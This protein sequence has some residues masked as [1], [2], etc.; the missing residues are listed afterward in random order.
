M[1]CV[2]ARGDRDQPDSRPLPTGR[3]AHPAEA[4]D[5]NVKASYRTGTSFRSRLS[6]PRERRAPGERRAVGQP[7]HPGGP[8]ALADDRAAAGR[9]GATG[10]GPG[11]L[12]ARAAV[13]RLAQ[14]SV[15]RLARH[16]P[17]RVQ[18]SAQGPPAGRQPAGGHRRAAPG[19]PGHGRGHLRRAA[20]PRRAAL[21]GGAGRRAGPARRLRAADRADHHAGRLVLGPAAGRPGPAAVAAQA[22]AVGHRPG[23]ARARAVGDDRPGRRVPDP[24]RGVL[25][26]DLGARLAARR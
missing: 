2:R 13:H 21:A 23:R 24:A 22:D 11:R 19:G 15:Q 26:G 10:A 14:V 25:R 17:P 8:A 6:R 1:R 3:Q 20:A 9:A 4:L 7:D 5:A 12:P 16:R 18:G